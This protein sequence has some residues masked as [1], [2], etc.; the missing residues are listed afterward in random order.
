MISSPDLVLAVQRQ[1]KKLSFWVL[2]AAFLVGLAGLSKEAAVALQKNVHGDDDQPSLF[3]D[4]MR[5]MHK[6]LK[7]CE[8][9]YEMT[10]V[11]VQK[12][13]ASMDKFAKDGTM[14]VDL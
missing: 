5:A 4:G 8:G 1:P 10:L 14:Q 2:E 3:M 9:L 6:E 13:A 11:A 12:L 7:P